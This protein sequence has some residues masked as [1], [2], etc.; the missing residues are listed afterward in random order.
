LK[1]SNK[2]SLSSSN[3]I[4]DNAIVS[5]HWIVVDDKNKYPI[6]PDI[7]YIEIQK[8]FKIGNG[9]LVDTSI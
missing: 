5:N 7:L 4:L 8:H 9:N 3:D 6:A 2:F 1:P